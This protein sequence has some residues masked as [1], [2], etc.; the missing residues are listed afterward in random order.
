MI[1]NLSA[2]K[3]KAKIRNKLLSSKRFCW[4]FSHAL[5]RE[6]PPDSSVNMD[7]LLLIQF[8]RQRTTQSKHIKYIFHNRFAASIQNRR[9]HNRSNDNKIIETT[10]LKNQT[11]N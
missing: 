7:L 5:Q 9:D 10:K 4:S 3:Q 11:I 1:N 2:L 6:R 8:S